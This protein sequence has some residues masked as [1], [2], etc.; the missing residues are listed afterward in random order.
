MPRSFSDKHDS[1]AVEDLLSQAKDG[2]VFEQVAKLN[3][4]GFSDDSALPSNLE[5]RSRRLKSLPVSSSPR[6]LL[7]HSKSMTSYADKKNRG[8]VSSVSSF[9]NL[10]RNSCPLDASVEET[11]FFSGCNCNPNVNT[12]RGGALG[13]FY[14]SGRIGSSSARFCQQG[15]ILNPTTQTLNLLPKENSRITSSSLTSIELASPSSSLRPKE[16]MNKSK[17]RF[18]RSWFDKLFL[19]QAMGCLQGKSLSK[20][21]RTKESCKEEIYWEEEFKKAKKRVTKKEFIINDL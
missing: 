3:C 2:Y 1:A 4:S 19:A 6:R 20:I 18:L 13:D 8:N 10:A 5:T 17:S 12:T 21:K 16:G 7:S 14:D 9:S 11:M 15:K